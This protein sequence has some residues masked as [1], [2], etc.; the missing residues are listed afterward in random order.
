M[1][2]PFLGK[3]GVI[4]ICS[5]FLI[6]AVANDAKDLT[7]RLQGEPIPRCAVWSVTRPPCR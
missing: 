6:P 5:G 2:L 7:A 1:Q 4:A 3:L